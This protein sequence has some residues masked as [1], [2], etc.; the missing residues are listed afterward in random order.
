MFLEAESYYLFEEY[1]EAL[2][3]YLEMLK[4]QPDNAF[5]NY[6]AGSCYLNIPGEKNLAIEF[7]KKAIEDI[8]NRDRRPTFR[9][10]KAPMDALF[11]LGYAY[12]INYQFEKALDMY[13]EFR[14]NINNTVYNID[15]VNEHIEATKN[16]IESTKNPVFFLEENLGERI[17]TRF[18]ETNPVVSGNKKILVFTRRLPF[19]DGVFFSKKTSEGEWSWPMEITPQIVS[20]GDCY[21]VSLSYEGDE[22]YLYKSDNLVGNIY[23]SRLIDG[24]W[25]PIK[26]LN[27]NINTNYWESHASISKDG[28]TLY[29]T[30][31]RPGGIGGLDIY[32]SKRNNLGDWGPAVNMGPNINTPYNEETPFITED[33]R[34]L[35]FS[36]Y[37]HYNIGG[38]DIFYSSLLDNGQW[39]V[40]LNAGY[41][42]NTPDDDL[43]F[44]PVKNRT[45]AFF[46]KHDEEGFG[47][48]DIFRYEFFSDSH[49]RK[50]LLKGVMER[51]D[52]LQ[53]SARARVSLIDPL[54]GDKKYTVTPD[55][56][57][58]EYEIT[59][60]AGD[61]KVLFSDEGHDDIIKSLE[62]PLER[63]DSEIKSDVLMERTDPVIPGIAE[64]ITDTIILPRETWPEKTLGIEKH[65]HRILEEK[66]IKIP[67]RLE[68]GTFLEVE[69]Y[70]DGGLIGTENIDI[71]RRRF[72][73]GYI[74]EPGENLLKFRYTDPEGEIIEEQVVISFH[75]PV[76]EEML[77]KVKNGEKRDSLI[78][79]L[80]YAA[81]GSMQNA[82][83]E[84]EISHPGIASPEHLV[85]YL[86]TKQAFRDYDSIFHSAQEFIA[87]L[88]PHV[89]ENLGKFLSGLIKEDNVPGSV[90]ELISLIIEGSDQYGYL[91]WEILEV[92]PKITT[93]DTTPPGDDQEAP[94]DRLNFSLWWLII[95]ALLLLTLFYFKGK[96][97]KRKH[98]H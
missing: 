98:K 25:T 41:G 27:E 11:N 93:T 50:F 63:P 6:R 97:T 96:I 84:M 48:M 64:V 33:G 80:L 12:H 95:L 23:V 62:V 35:Y 85:E 31:N 90:N 55:P 5:L 54:S 29:F 18:S 71:E 14:N 82:L 52:G 9:T 68:P 24:Q 47:N 72:V 76:S 10:R 37:G 75:P 8:D 81:P 45:Y 32:Y 56:K 30:S 13:N 89:S 3:L 92:L 28:N 67:M 26:K 53:T 2:P 44:N 73:Y 78:K 21:P 69:K 94:E 87:A 66:H 19:Y 59:I 16:A 4:E 57:T 34:T 60:E 40:P 88:M 58:G 65:Q 51:K 86:H 39:S 38:Y 91:K 1:N 46:S 42:I 70:L 77:S 7:L 74:P 36:S 79:I 22:L 15:I 17:N 43:F 49:P 83:A 20:E 61:W